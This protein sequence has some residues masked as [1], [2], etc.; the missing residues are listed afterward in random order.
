MKYYLYLKIHQITKLK[1]LGFTKSTDPLK[2]RGSGLYWLRHL[3]THGNFV[4]T[5][6]LLEYYSLEEIK[7]Q[8]LYYSTLWNVT[9]SEEF[10]N[11]K[12]E[13]GQGGFIP[14][15]KYSAEHIQ[16]RTATRKTKS[17]EI[18]KK[19]ADSNKGRSRSE[20]TKHLM[21]QRKRELFDD[22]KRANYSISKMGTRNPSWKGEIHTPDGVFTTLAQAAA[23]Y[24]CTDANIGRRVKS[25]SPKWAEWYR[26]PKSGAQ[27]G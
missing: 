16:K 10:A 13:T 27:H 19:V 11:L 1:Y 18:Y 4:D 20:E 24:N 26:L 6:I 15:F 14:G 8:G 2:Y 22:S 7:E 9:D 3:K 25:N 12:P 5:Q 17:E 23:H 21:S